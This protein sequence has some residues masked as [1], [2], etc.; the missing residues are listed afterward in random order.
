MFQYRALS[1]LRCFLDMTMLLTVSAQLMI[2]LPL[3]HSLLSNVLQHFIHS[4]LTFLFSVW[5]F[6]PFGAFG[7]SKQPDLVFRGHTSDISCID[8]SGS[9]GIMA[10]GSWD[11]GVRIWDLISGA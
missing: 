11:R 3:L 10:S 7:H 1:S 5:K 8:L 9:L 2:F 6:R 4:L